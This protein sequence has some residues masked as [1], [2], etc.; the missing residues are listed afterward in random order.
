MGPR[1][2]DAQ[3]ENVV[4]DGRGVVRATEV[5]V[6]EVERQVRVAADRRPPLPLCAP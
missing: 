5:R 6:A 4:V 2:K 3:H 1:R